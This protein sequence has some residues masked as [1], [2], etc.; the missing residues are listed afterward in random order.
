[1]TEGGC[2]DTPLC[3]IDSGNSVLVCTHISGD[4]SSKLTIFTKQA[5]SYSPADLVGDWEANFLSSGPTPW[6]A[7]MSD[8]TYPDG[9]YK[10]TV[11]ASDESST[12]TYGQIS[13]SATGV[14][15]CI[16]GGC[17]STPNNYA[18]FM[19]A[20]KTV[21]VGT[22]GAASG[23]DAQLSFFT[24]QAASYSIDDLAG[25]WQGNSLA[26][27]PGAPYW[28]RDTVTIDADGTYSVS[29]NGSNGSSG[30]GTGTLSI[31]S[32]GVITCIS[33]DCADRTHM[34]IMDAGKTVA[35]GTRT[36]PDGATR[37]IKIFTKDSVPDTPAV[38]AAAAAQAGS[39]QVGSLT[40][41]ITPKTAVSAGAMW[42]VDIGVWQNS[43]TTVGGLSVGSH[44]VAFKA[45][46]GWNTPAGQ[47]IRISSGK[48]ASA[49]G[50]Y[51][52]QTGSLKVTITP[53]AAAKAGAEWN[54]NGGAWQ[55]S[56][57]TVGN[58]PIG[59]YTVN[60]NT[61][62]GWTS[63]ASRPVNIAYN[64]TASA[65]GLYTEQFGSLKVT[66][67]PD[68]AVSAG[69]E[70]K[71]DSGG[72][73]KSGAVVGGLSVGSHKVS[74][75]A[76]TGWNTPAIQTVNI[77]NGQTAPADGLY[78]QQTGS[79]KVTITPAAAVSAGAMWNVDKGSW[80]TS[81]TT[82]SGITVGSHV[83]YFAPI[84]GWPAPAPVPVTIN[85]GK[86]TT[87]TGTYKLKP[88]GSLT[89]TLSPATA[90]AAGAQWNVD[91]GA[92]QNSGATVDDLSKGSHT[93]N[94]NTIDGW[95]S[96]ESQTVQIQSGKTATATGTYVE[97]VAVSGQTSCTLTSGC[98]NGSWPDSTW[99]CKPPTPGSP[100]PNP[101][102][103]YNFTINATAGGPVGS[104]FSYG[105]GTGGLTAP[106]PLTVNCNS[107]TVYN[108][109]QCIRGQNDP[110]LASISLTGI[111]DGNGS[112]GSCASV[113]TTV[114][115][116][117]TAP[118]VNS[119]IIS[120]GQVPLRNQWDSGTVTC[121]VGY[122][123]LCQ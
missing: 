46:D 108:N 41:L 39:T 87:A 36:W 33:G 81:G 48:T 71:V 13:I 10:G 56:G 52:Q 98:C 55:K 5:A 112:N 23:Q 79:L 99:E 49:T 66:V 101:P 69:A 61:I 32:D 12:D 82:L 62:T 111:A 94:F 1:M 47:T 68:A 83:V 73:Q 110:A 22:S 106:Q 9:T 35:A 21:S 104:I 38:A 115:A 31:S 117:V 74:F 85:N 20:D 116:E 109:T 80:Q 122:P 97:V 113:Q 59:S 86:T 119:R 90:V 120:T 27:G 118:A 6:W 3:R 96:P 89:V 63:P 88:G 70:W 8:R 91:G 95:T 50:V 67:G 30:I 64:K 65:G 19:G 114:W 7:K 11:T 100:Q 105:L 51:V 60:F 2:S 121:C 102:L 72:W 107:W 42:N 53:A 18:A 43:G 77:L 103:A 76:V 44:K 78:V 34:S 37:E 54:V 28:E 75:K 57:A 25:I 4:G 16:T 14:I 26:S 40:G 45:V 93:V 58:L 17:L 15:T 29:W 123:D 92:W 24:K 84:V